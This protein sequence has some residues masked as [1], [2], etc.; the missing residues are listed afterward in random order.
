MIKSIK[1]K[2]KQFTMKKFTGRALKYCGLIVSSE[3]QM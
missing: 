1:C 3:E 2:Q